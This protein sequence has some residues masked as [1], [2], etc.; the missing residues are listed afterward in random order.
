MAHYQA[1]GQLFFMDDPGAGG[2]AAVQRWASSPRNAPSAPSPLIADSSNVDID[3]LQRPRPTPQS[4]ARRTRPARRSAPPPALRA[5]R[6][7]P[8]H[9]HRPTPI[10]GQPRVENG[11]RG[12]GHQ[13]SATR[14]PHRRCRRV[15]SRG[16]LAGQD[17]ENAPSR[18]RPARLPP[19]GR[20]VDR[21]VVAHRRMADQQGVRLRPSNPGPAR[22]P[23]GS[24]PAT[25]S[26]STAKTTAA[27]CASHNSS[28]SAAG[29]PRPSP[30]E[31]WQTPTRGPGFHPTHRLIPS[32]APR[33]QP[34]HTT[35]GQTSR[36]RRARTRAMRRCRRHDS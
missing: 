20:T 30:T 25:S 5:A 15:R 36:P 7:R 22:R 1:E 23:S 14:T 18:L 13:A 9:L 32:R 33:P 3:R 24:S 8:H 28:A 16:H 6:G 11:T 17:L 27:S 26:A 12:R 21:S 10:P 31:S 29:K 2:E 34:E 35:P 19:A 4:R